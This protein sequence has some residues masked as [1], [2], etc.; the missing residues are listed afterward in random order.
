[1]LPHATV[2]HQTE[3]RIRI[4]IPRCRRDREYFAKLR[5][6]LGKF[7]GIERVEANP[8]TASVLIH[9][10]S[11]KDRIADYAE[12]AELFAL[13][14]DETPLSPTSLA[15]QANARVVKLNEQLI[16]ATKGTLD[17]TTVS[18]FGL[19]VGGVI[20]GLMGKAFLPSG[21]DLI[22][23]A[24]TLLARHDARARGASLASSPPARVAADVDEGRVQRRRIRRAR[25]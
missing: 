18:A 6:E 7:E 14:V 22:W 8:N 21:S 16:E 13:A 25:R 24:V 12:E 19:A 1:M 4:H 11:T 15:S 3:H 17:L 5:D 2:S 20:R 9:H 10:R 23:W